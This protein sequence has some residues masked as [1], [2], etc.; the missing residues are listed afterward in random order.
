MATLVRFNLDIGRMAPEDRKGDPIILRLDQ[1]ESVRSDDPE[2][3]CTVR[4]TSGDEHRLY[5][6]FEDMIK[7][8]HIREEFL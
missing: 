4:M 6:P 3:T 5:I 7:K 1:I 8:L 2:R